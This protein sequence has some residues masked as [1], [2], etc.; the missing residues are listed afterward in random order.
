MLT[1]VLLSRH[2]SLGL[3]LAILEKFVVLNIDTVFVR[4]VVFHHADLFFHDENALT[5]DCHSL[6]LFSRFSRHFLDYF[7]QDLVLLLLLRD[8]LLQLLVV[9]V[10][11]WRCVF[12][13]VLHFLNQIL[14]EHVNFAA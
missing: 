13:N 12:L 3:S 10:D 5:A 8:V 2:Q 7:D 11:L 1:V 9:L 6:A 14:H 4:L